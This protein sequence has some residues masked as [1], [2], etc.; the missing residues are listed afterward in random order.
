M[1]TSLLIAKI[2]AVVYLSIGVGSLFSP[3]YLKKVVEDFGKSAAANYLGGILAL[4]MGSLIINF[5]NVWESNWTILITALGWAALIKGF[6]LLAFPEIMMHF[7]RHVFKKINMNLYS[8][9]VLLLGAF[10]AYQGFL[11]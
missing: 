10:F 7:Y 4:V 9:I 5:H 6:V 1:A 3:D 2:I 8:I 11:A